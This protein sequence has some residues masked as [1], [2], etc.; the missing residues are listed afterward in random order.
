MRLIGRLQRIQ[1]SCVLV[2]QLVRL[3]TVAVMNLCQ[4]RL[5]HLEAPHAQRTSYF[6]SL[7]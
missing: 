7:M 3:G 1:L 5:L 6:Q 2:D 4:L